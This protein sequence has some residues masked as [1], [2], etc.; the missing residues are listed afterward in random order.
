M[1]NEKELFLKY[2]EKCGATSRYSGDHTLLNSYRSNLLQKSNEIIDSYERNN[3]SEFL[4][5]KK[6]FQEELDRLNAKKNYKNL[7][8]DNLKG[9]YTENFFKDNAGETVKEELNGKEYKVNEEGTGF[10]E[11]SRSELNIDIDHIIPLQSEIDK[12]KNS[13]FYSSIISY[14]GLDKLKEILNDSDNL[15]ASD[16]G[17]NRSKGEK[18]NSDI[19]KVKGEEL[20]EEQKERLKEQ[21]EAAQASKR[22]KI[23][24]A[25]TENLA[26]DVKDYYIRGLV[27]SVIDTE[28]QYIK[29]TLNN[30]FE[31]LLLRKKG[32]GKGER[33]I[34]IKKTVKYT[35]NWLRDRFIEISIT[36]KDYLN[37]KKSF[38]KIIEGIFTTIVG[39][40]FNT[41]LLIINAFTS[42]I[43]YL[44]NLFK[45]IKTYRNDKICEAKNAIVGYIK[46]NK[47]FGV[48]I[49]TITGLITGTVLIGV[50]ENLFINYFID[51]ICLT[52]L[53]YYDYTKYSLDLNEFAKFCEI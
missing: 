26:S 13:K 48:A 42:I 1:I 38:K 45:N 52:L 51:L 36:I 29:S 34:N 27:I 35:I 46:G 12:L 53:F 8:R 18:N 37:L 24:K 49:A 33:K 43:N 4:R 21:E 50:F 11:G 32:N 47:I 28:V 30:K 22:N 15:A 39:I 23:L 10:E 41:A 2:D 6:E 20:T 7:T 31:S 25:F 44:I 14:I 3:F 5:S 9:E 17:F 19:N 40:F 16:A